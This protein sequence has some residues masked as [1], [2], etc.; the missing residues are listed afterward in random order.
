MK[1]LTLSLQRECHVEEGDGESSRWDY[2][3]VGVDVQLVVHDALSV[4]G[5]VE[6]S[7]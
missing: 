3:Y 7:V 1:N 5:V 4:T 6:A 2:V